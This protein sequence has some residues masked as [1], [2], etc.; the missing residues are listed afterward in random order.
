MDLDMA[1]TMIG[2]ATF[3]LYPYLERYLRS[4]TVTA[5]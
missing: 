1:M 4:W 5:G 3:V 2:H